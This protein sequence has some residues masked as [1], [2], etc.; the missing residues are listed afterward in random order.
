MR[1]VGDTSAEQKNSHPA[2][3]ICFQRIPVLSCP[4]SILGPGWFPPFSCSVRRFVSSVCSVWQLPGTLCV[5][6]SMLQKEHA[7]NCWLPPELCL[8]LFGMDR[9]GMQSHFC[10]RVQG[11]SDHAPSRLTLALSPSE[12]LLLPNTVHEGPGWF[13]LPHCFLQQ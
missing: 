2:T 8:G 5:A 11:D 1:P 7:G 4:P 10:R 6:M 3:V 9:Y 12:A 13:S